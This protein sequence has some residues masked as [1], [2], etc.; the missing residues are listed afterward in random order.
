MRTPRT[1]RSTRLGALSAVT[2]VLI[3]GLVLAACGDDGSADGTNSG[4]ESASETD[5]ETDEATA[6]TVSVSATMSTTADTTVDPDSSTD[7]SA[8]ETEPTGEPGG[9]GQPGAKW[10]APDWD[11]NV[12]DALA[13]RAQLDALA[14]SAGVMVGAEVTPATLTGLSD[15]TDVWEGRPSLADA[16]SPAFA[17]LMT[18]AFQEFVDL[19][20]AGPQELVVDGNWEPGDNGGILGTA[21]RGFNEGG[22]EVRQIVDKGGFGGGVM[23][24]W[25]VAQTGGTIEPATIDAIAAAWGNNAAL[26]ALDPDGMSLLTDAANYSYQMGFHADMAAA[27]AD[28]KAFSADED[29]GAERDAALVTFFNLWE[30]SMFARA[31][32]YGER[33]ATTLVT[34]ATATDYASVLHDL[35]EAFGVMIG[36]YGITTPDAGPLA[37]GARIVTDEQVLEALAAY[38]VDYDAL[39]SSTTGLLLESLPEFETAN[40]ALEAVVMDVYGIDAAT[41]QSYRMPTAG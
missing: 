38:G 29:C 3:A 30:Q 37:G 5:G 20:E 27:L 25:A 9:C 10:E 13:L 8:T 41:I 19:I 26:S 1:S 16:A 31:M 15:L 7:A 35:G 24:E 17:V 34:A 2:P 18:D 14:G 22:I 36:F 23:Y 39:G 28:A 4:T 40:E 32:F 12:A 6:S 11:A 33:G 21:D